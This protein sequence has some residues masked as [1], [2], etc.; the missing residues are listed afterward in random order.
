V[1]KPVKAAG[2]GKPAKPV[3]ASKPAKHA[4]KKHK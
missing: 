2:A 3:K 4:G 1:A